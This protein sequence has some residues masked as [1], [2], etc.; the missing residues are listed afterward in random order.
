MPTLNTSPSLARVDRT[1]NVHT[2]PLHALELVLMAAKMRRR[3][4]GGTALLAAYTPRPTMNLDCHKGTTPSTAKLAHAKGAGSM[5]G[6]PVALM[7]RGH[8]AQVIQRTRDLHGLD[9][10]RK[11]FGA[12]LKELEREHR[13]FLHAGKHGGAA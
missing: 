12:G 9:E 2:I 8:I 1:L 11:T 3:N 7:G 6:M 4:Q 5:P 10:V 13:F